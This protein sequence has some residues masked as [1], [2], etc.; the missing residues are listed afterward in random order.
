MT[1]VGMAQRRDKRDRHGGC[2]NISDFHTSLR[3]AKC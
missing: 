1:P 3:G 2:T